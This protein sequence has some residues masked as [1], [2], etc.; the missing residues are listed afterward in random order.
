MLPTEPSPT[1]ERITKLCGREDGEIPLKNGRSLT[2]CL[3][4]LL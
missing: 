4:N 1:L 3:S 2:T